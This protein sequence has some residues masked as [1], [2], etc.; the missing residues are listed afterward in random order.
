MS[1]TNPL[2]SVGIITYNSAST[3][4]ETLNSIASQTYKNIEIIISDDC[5]TDDT[6][7]ICREWATINRSRFARTEILETQ[8]N[9]GISSNCNK[10]IL[11]SKGEWV[12]LIA[13]DDLLCKDCIEKYI[14]FVSLKSDD[15][16]VVFS[17]IQ[18]FSDIEGRRIKG[19]I[20]PKSNIIDLFNN[21][22]SKQQLLLLLDND[23]ILPAPSVFFRTSFIQ[24]H[25]YDEKYKYEEDYPM[26]ISLTK[27]GEKLEIMDSLTVNYRISD[28]ISRVTKRYYSSNYMQTRSLFFW[29]V[30]LDLYKEY[31]SPNGYNKYRKFLLTNEMIEA[32][33]GNKK[34]L[35]NSIK[36]KIIR[37]IV[38][39]LV[40]YK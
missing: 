31:P 7:N 25:L 13:G 20:I 12:K 26:W 11:H 29:G 36:V 3:I 16:N 40:R 10:V 8:S 4:I 21:A 15:L 33:T 5:S 17:R 38:N 6:V 1:C 34:S 32:F 2:V 27:M 37:L 18:S 23:S 28:S 30:A 39:K 22:S 19:N 24:N 14:N 35:I 9:K